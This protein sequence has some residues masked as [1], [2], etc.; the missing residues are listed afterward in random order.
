MHRYALVTTNEQLGQTSCDEH[1]V[2]TFNSCTICVAIGHT[3]IVY[4]DQA[5]PAFSAGIKC[6]HSINC[7]RCPHLPCKPIL[8]TPLL[9]YP[10]CINRATPPLKQAVAK[11]SSEP[12]P[13]FS[14]AYEPFWNMETTSGSSNNDRGRVAVIC[15]GFVVILLVVVALDVIAGKY[16]LY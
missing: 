2:Q 9:A 7:Q 11:G 6:R 12:S 14:V 5:A 4:Y 1:A 16:R 15:R 10:R 3:A 8:S 13:S